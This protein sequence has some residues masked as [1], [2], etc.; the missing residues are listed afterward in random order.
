MCGPTIHMRI[1]KLNHS[2]RLFDVGGAI[3]FFGI[4]AQEPR[5]HEHAVNALKELSTLGYQ[6]PSEEKPIRIFPALTSGGFSGR[7]AGGW[8]PGVI[9]LRQYPQSQFDESIYLRHELFHEVNYLTCNGRQPAWAEEAAAM[10][11]S[12]ELNSQMNGMWPSETELQDFKRHV[13]QGAELSSA[14]RLVLARLVAIAGWPDKPCAISPKLQ[15]V[16]GSAFDESGSRSYLLMSL[17]SGRIL[18]SDG[19]QNSRLPPGS[20]LKLLYAA[21]LNQANPD[22]LSAELVASDT[23]RLLQ[24]RTNFQPSRYRLLLSP[25]DDKRLTRTLD[26]DQTHW[27]IYLGARDANGQFLL[28]ASL[29]ELA[30]AVRAAL[31]SEPDYFKGLT[32][33]GALPQSTLFGQSE[34]DK[35]L[36]R[37]MQ[38]MAK[39]GTVSTADGRPLVG[40]LLL[41]WPAPHPVFLAVFRQKGKSGAAILPKAAELLRQWQKHY[42]PRFASVRVHLLSST[43]RNS[44]EAR[45]IC[46]EIRELQQRF[47]V[48]GEFRIVSSAHGSR[49]ERVVRGILHD[50]DNDLVVLETDIL[51]YVDAVL[52]AEAQNLPASARQAMRAVIAWNATHGRHRHPDSSS[53]CDTTHCMVFLGETANEYKHRN[54]AIDI[55]LLKLLDNLASDA[56]L[57]WLP[58]AAG[59]DERWNKQIT[60]TELNTQFNENQILDIRRER[61]KNGDLFIHVYYPNNE[62]T[63]SCEIFRNALRLPSCPDSIHANMHQQVW[64]FQGLGAGHG[65]GLSV[66]RAKALAANGHSAEQILI[67]A[68]RLTRTDRIN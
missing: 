38:V 28:E 10:H 17:Q 21:S 2:C 33:N 14:D 49:S 40:H 19:D 45:T 36:L 22:I 6:L 59:G 4:L 65:L 9:Y 57:S 3:L 63:I 52:A 47:T 67:D 50:T 11:F 61:R 35:K 68:Y 46:P 55:Q 64:A 12:G 58:F 27:D 5:L 24:R 1:R 60:F 20:L 31:L 16:L 30:L 13:R 23:E 44:W 54:E 48:C 7:H 26:M 8:R 53:L 41:A 62:E 39:T 37:Q 15:D 25:I 66:A 42:P 51:S 29:P 34:A 43:D 56:G 18:E 32:A